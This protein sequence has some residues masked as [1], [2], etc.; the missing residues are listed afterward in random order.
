MSDYLHNHKDFSALLR[1]VGQEMNIEPI[2]VEKDYW[3][4][5]VL[6]GLKQLGFNFELKGGTSLSK[7]YKIIKR[8]SEDIDIHITPPAEM[9]INENPKNNKP[10]NIEAR[11]KFYNWLAD[12]IKMNG[13]SSTERDTDFDD[14]EAYRSGG[15]RLYYNSYTEPMKGIKE[16]I[17]LE[18]GF[19]KV[20]PN[21]TINISSW[22]YDKAVQQKVDVI[23]NRAIEIICYHPG[24]TFVEKLQ[25]IA[26]KFRQEQQSGEERQNLM[27]QY[28]DVFSLLKNEKVQG[29]IGT[30][31]YKAHKIERFPKVDYNLPIVENEAFLL[32][33]EEL[34]N[35]F[36]SRYEKT[37]ALYYNGQPNFDEMLAEIS[38]WVGKL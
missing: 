3:I 35:R 17:L 16:G 22:A 31:E 18:A 13:I 26:T 14:T 32:T 33:D 2:L 6:Y 27:R 21:N 4:M 36:R 30:D 5:H 11:K 12:T 29:F 38:K 25:T 20:T 1:I 28:Y 34:R 23:D 9:G 8:F 10:R 7:G 37:A 24:Y 15:I 19:D